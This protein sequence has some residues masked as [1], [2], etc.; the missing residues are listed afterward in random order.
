MDNNEAITIA[1]LRGEIAMLWHRVLVAEERQRDAE[2]A[3]ALCQNA[4]AVEHLIEELVT[5]RRI[6]HLARSYRDAEIECMG[7]FAAEPRVRSYRRRVELDALLGIPTE[8]R[9]AA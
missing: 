7:S 3:L 9:G 8:E 2:A 5:L 6:R 1:E 4:L